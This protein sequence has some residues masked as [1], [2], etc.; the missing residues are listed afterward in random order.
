MFGVPDPRFGQAVSAMVAV[1][2][3]APV[4][5]AQLIERVRSRLAPFK[6]RAASP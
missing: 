6:A 4:T 3:G 5:D 2:A 1:V